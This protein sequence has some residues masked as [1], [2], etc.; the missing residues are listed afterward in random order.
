MRPIAGYQ[1]AS[2]NSQ[3]WLKMTDFRSKTGQNPGFDVT[4][5]L[6]GKNCKLLIM[7]LLI[8]DEVQKNG[9]NRV[10]GWG[11]DKFSLFLPLFMEAGEV[12]NALDGTEFR[13]DFGVMTDSPY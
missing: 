10:G 1:K 7:S 11:P 5:S 2:K 13:D 3:F 6:T 12:R 4:E 9:R 8:A